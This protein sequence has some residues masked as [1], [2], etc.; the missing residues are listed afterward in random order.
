MLGCTNTLIVFRW[1]GP[2]CSGPSQRPSH[3]SGVFNISPFFIYDFSFFVLKFIWFSWLVFW[4]EKRSRLRLVYVSETW[5]DFRGAPFRLVAEGKTSTLLKD[6]DAFYKKTQFYLRSFMFLGSSPLLGSLGTPWDS[7]G[8]P[9]ASICPFACAV[10]VSHW[11]SAALF[12][13][14]SSTASYSLRMSGLVCSHGRPYSR[15]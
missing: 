13:Q 5:C 3:Y 8:G 15:T 1:H 4:A 2:V 11:Y 12:C 10:Y 9:G 6:F 7:L 14:V